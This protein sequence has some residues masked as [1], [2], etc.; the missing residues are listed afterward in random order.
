MN[1]SLLCGWVVLAASVSGAVE[2]GEFEWCEPFA[3]ADAWQP[4]PSW[5]ANASPTASVE[6]DGRV[7]RFG[8]DEPGRGMKWSASMAGVELSELPYLVLRYRAERFDVARDD[9]FVYLKDDVPGT[10]L[11]A[12]G[13][14]EVAA[15]GQWHVAVVDVTTRTRGRAV[16]QIAIQVQ[17]GPEGGVRLWVDWIAMMA[18]PPEQAEW[19]GPAPESTPDRRIPLAGSR[20][21]ARPDW[22]GNPAGEGARRAGHDG[23]TALFAVDSAQRGMKWSWDLPEPLALEGHRFASFRYRAV[24]ARPTGDYAVA[25][26]GKQRGAGPGYLALIPATELICDGRW[27]TLDVDI[28]SV[29]AE[30][31]VADTL[32]VQVQAG[33]PRATLEV[34]DL[35]LSNTRS[36]S[37]LA[38][39]VDWRPGARFDGFRPWPIDSVATADADSWRR[40]LR[41]GDWFTE[42][43]VTVCGIP[44]QLASGGSALAA[45]PLRDKSQLR[46]PGGVAAGE[47][48]LVMMA[49]FTG[50]EEPAYGHGRLRAIRDVDRFRL[51]LEYAGGTVDECVP[52]N[53]DT[54]D[55]GIVEGAQVVVAAADGSK[56]LESIVVC[57]RARQA[58]FAV[59]A[60][61]AR[62]D[63]GRLFPEALDES[64]PLRV[65]A[66]DPSADVALEAVLDT[67]GSPILKRLVHRPSGWDL[68]AEPCSI[69]RL[70]VDGEE[71]APE[72]FERSPNGGPIAWY[73][74]R[75][76]DGLRVGIEASA[77]PRGEYTVTA[78]VDHR[79]AQEHTVELAAPVIGPYRLGENADDAYYWFP[80]RGSAFDNRPA[81]H[82]ERYSG[83]FPVQFIDTFSPADGRGLSLRTLDE[84]CLRKDYLLEKQSGALS[85]GVEYPART[86]KPGERFRTAPTVIRATDGD[87]RRG[88][89]AYREWVR[90]WH[91]PRSPRKP[92][93]REIFNFRQRFLW[94]LDPLFDAQTKTFH[95]D[96]AV[97]EARREF[98]G[99]D[100]LHIFDWGNCGRLGRIYGRTGDHS[101]YEHL[102]GRDAFRL[103]IR[104][105]QAQGVPTGLYI[106]GYLLEERGKLGQEFGPA[107]QL[108]GR[109]GRGL[110]WPQSTEMFVCPGVAA[111]REV[112]AS[113]Y[114]TKVEQL[115][116]DGMYIDQFG[117]ANQGKN[118][119]SSA[120]GHEV[121][122]D[123]VVTERDCTEIIRR[124]IDRA[125]PN[126]AVYTE[127]TPVDVTTQ[128]Q[129]GS[130][131]YAMF[132]AQRTLT[133]VPLNAARFALP[134]FKTIEILFC[135]K[136]TG[137]WATGVK[138]VFFN[139]EAIWIEGPAGEWFEPA[140]REAIRRCYRILRKH[141]DAF[142]SLEPAPLVPT[143]MGGVFANAFPGRDETVYTFY[144]ARHRTVRGT[145]LR[146][147]GA[148]A[149]TY[150]D[151]WHE[152]PA[153]VRREGADVLIDL[154]I[155]PHDVGCLVVD[156]S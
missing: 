55:F 25:V 51:R 140:T 29:G 64:P 3:T 116:V 2:P 117:F 4:E 100:Y 143:E 76:V 56:R 135:D 37:K 40:H 151:A 47:V 119:Y 126:V 50:S 98:G 78:H 24:G 92:W 104:G 141:R 62:T 82:R 125:K 15:D 89:D 122:S 81:T 150:H 91:A 155:G 28:R 87:W 72:R 30:I 66:S 12:I 148:D 41:I 42:P 35:R 111:W 11:Q 146:L 152:R 108:I 36:R 34:S 68:L 58:A 131:T 71:I 139:G 128:L 121:P 14:N 113:T 105:V 112:Q 80:K 107:W 106:E 19:I 138:W 132:S 20:W 114:A 49:A 45:T 60:V 63:G 102:G 136:P 147:P 33:E 65:A 75:G 8:V 44:F 154:E 84:R 59:A 67:A 18:S 130:F 1:R 32:A 77:A 137:S 103:A 110:Y 145:V 13:L 79:G 43:A 39:A 90:T 99:I 101:P 7:A 17:S 21:Q 53:V 95:L 26:L 31:P 153:T 123:P 156:E 118:C 54:R 88:F 74:I 134:C 97:E 142:T 57:D 85:V 86:V 115:D 83:L 129:D 48:Y 10:E 61:T 94:W 124:R 38:D 127:E 109:D 52:M 120:H 5:L 93:F 144:N 73:A 16:S 70:R 133:R 69:V 27:H 96:R 149:A 46:L 23:E 6:C 22:L 9:Y